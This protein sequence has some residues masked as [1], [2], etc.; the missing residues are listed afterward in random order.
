MKASGRGSEGMTVLIAIGL[1]TLAG[2]AVQG[3]PHNFFQAANRM[4]LD[5]AEK[6]V[7]WVQS[8]S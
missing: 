2:I 7:L 3:G 4:L 1:L 8:R 5:G 6:I